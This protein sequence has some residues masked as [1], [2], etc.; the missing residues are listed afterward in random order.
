MAGKGDKPRNCSSKK[1]KK[2]Y[3]EIKWKKKQDKDIKD[4]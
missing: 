2:N 4:K 1:F 3:G